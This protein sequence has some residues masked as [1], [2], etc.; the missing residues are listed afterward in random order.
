VRYARPPGVRGWT[1][2]RSTNCS[3]DPAGHGDASPPRT[4]DAAVRLPPD[5]TGPVDVELARLVD[6]IPA[7]S[8]LP[9]R[10]RCEVEWE[11]YIH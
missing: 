11:G 7:E 9:G 2:W 3:A 4:T 8:T 10:S 1:G 5:L 6:T